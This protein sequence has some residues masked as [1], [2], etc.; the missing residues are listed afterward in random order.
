MFEE[1]T[2]LLADIQDLETEELPILKADLNQTKE[3]LAALQREIDTLETES[4]GENSP[5]LKGVIAK[6][7]EKI[8]Q[9]Y[10][11][12]LSALAEKKRTITADAAKQ[13]AD[14]LDKLDVDFG[15]ETTLKLIYE[16]IE[17][18]REKITS[19]EIEGLR[20]PVETQKQLRGR[21]I[22][23]ERHYAAYAQEEQPFCKKVAEKVALKEI[24]QS[25]DN[26]KVAVGCMTGYIL[27]GVISALYLPIL[28]IAGYIGMTVLSVRDALRL[29]DVKSAIEKE[30]WLLE[31]SYE[32][33]EASYREDFQRKVQEA[34]DEADKYYQDALHD[35][36]EEEAQ[37]K[38]EYTNLLAELEIM[39]KDPNF[40]ARNLSVFRHKLDSLNA[41]K[42]EY[43]EQIEEA[44]AKCK[45][46]LE[47][48]ARLK[49]ELQ[50][51]RKQIEEKYM[52]ELKPGVSRLLTTELFLGFEKTEA[53]RT[54][55]FDGNA[56]V[57]FYSGETSDITELS[58]SIFLELLR[59]V[60]IASLAFHIMDTDL[61]APAFMPF[62]Q[63]ELSEVVNICSTKEQCVAVINSMHTA[64]E[65][66]NKSILPYANNIGD[67]NAQM[68]AKNSL[69]REYVFLLIQDSSGAILNNSRFQQLLKA[70]PRIGIIPII[71]LSAGWYYKQ[72]SGEGEEVEA[73]YQLLSAIPDNWF[74]Y[75]VENDAFIKRPKTFIETNLKRLEAGIAK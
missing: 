45:D 38:E 43:L 71:F 47:D 34:N 73:V 61:G 53:L 70:G 29:K 74:S 59:E 42:E 16:I 23:F 13:R 46:C 20:I 55:K 64:L 15:C 60:N 69:T 10:R 31:K 26:P 72:L 68:L 17:E 44:E 3:Q 30:F 1:Y 12:R 36:E 50:V 25:M 35:C 11:S 2:Q 19:T 41:E 8:E 27:T 63:E 24:F 6:E 62:T 22:V 5:H 39:E 32:N 58:M 7:A 48:I 54:F 21:A 75:S 51:L 67:F 66:R 65:E 9:D 33:L 57:I 40:I 49:S 4:L 14:L 28:A 37:L 56:S 52:G 18:Y